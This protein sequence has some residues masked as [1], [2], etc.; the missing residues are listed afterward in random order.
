LNARGFT[1]KLY[2]C[3]KVE[4]LTLNSQLTI[5]DKHSALGQT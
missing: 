5:L 1:I 3:L 4:S 2:P